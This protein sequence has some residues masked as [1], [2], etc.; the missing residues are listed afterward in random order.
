MAL[1]KNLKA[2]IRKHFGTLKNVPADLRGFIAAVND[3]Y[4]TIKES[5]DGYRLLAENIT[6]IIWTMDFDLKLQYVSPSCFPLTGYSADELMRMKID[7]YCAPAS[8][9]NAFKVLTHEL[10]R[11]KKENPD[12]NR[13]VFLDIEY[14]RKEGSTLWTEVKVTFLRKN[15]KPVGLIGVSRDITA[16]R[17]TEEKLRRSEELHRS[18]IESIEESYYEV[19]LTGRYVFVNSAFCKMLGYPIEEVVGMSFKQLMP[20]ESYKRTYELYYQVYTGGDPGQI[21]RDS[22]IKKD[23]TIRHAEGS[24]SLRYDPEGNIIGFCGIIRD[25]TEKIMMEEALRESEE[26]LRARNE[27]MEDDLKTAQRIQR[28]LLSPANPSLNWIK[29]DYRYLPL[30]AV[31][32]DYFSFI[33]LREGGLGVFI[34]DV[35]S[36]GVTAA[37]YLSLVK[38]TSERICRV[39]A[40]KPAEFINTLNTELYGNMPLS[41]LTATYGVFAM[42]GRGETCFTFSSAGH[43]YPILVRADSGSI[44]YVRCKGTILGMFEELEFHQKSVPL[45]KGDRIF[46]YTDGIPETINEKNDLIGYDRLPDLIR[47]CNDAALDS[48]LDNIITEINRFRGR[49][50]L[51][52]DIVLLGFEYLGN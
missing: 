29:A 48:T 42:D 39:F 21:T 38:A 35:S 33:Q 16:R 12:P 20:R 4:S 10:E 24:V 51:C 41:F 30:E 19:D 31:G 9:A 50:D 34:G 37:L 44:E 23:G 3:D 26:S 18:M 11:E 2:L 8:V 1:H 43:P 7:E 46:L 14:F 28:S 40:L 32:G 27:V 15:G 25:V 45:R 47:E 22:F 49:A 6:D 13:A 52:D 5:A 17:N 36:H